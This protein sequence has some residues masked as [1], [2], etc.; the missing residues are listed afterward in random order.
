MPTCA[1][2][3]KRMVEADLY[4]GRSLRD[5]GE[6]SDREWQRFLDEAVTPR[7]PMGL[8]VADLD[9][10]WR[11]MGMI[12]RERSKE[13]KIVL[14]GAFDDEAKLAAV[15]KAYEDRFRQQSVLLTETFVCAAF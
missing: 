9:G 10:Q 6:V 11:T 2:S 3:Q 8:S 4:F 14:P 12:V 7:F 5:G 15:R 13:L 1:T